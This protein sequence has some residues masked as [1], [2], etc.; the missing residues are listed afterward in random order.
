MAAYVKPHQ[1]PE[2]TTGDAGSAKR[3]ILRK[4]GPAKTRKEGIPGSAVD[5]GSTA[6]DGCALDEDDPNYDSEEDNRMNV[7]KR[8]PL[9]RD[10]PYKSTISLAAYKKR[11]EDIIDEYFVSGD[12]DDTAHYIMVS[13]GID[14]LHFCNLYIR[15]TLTTASNCR[16][17]TQL[18]TLMSL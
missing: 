17:L 3:N 16:T 7:P 4:G 9:Y 15:I 1:V 11:A 13:P 8:S 14:C 2:T 5:D 6:V 18:S 12:I 10:N